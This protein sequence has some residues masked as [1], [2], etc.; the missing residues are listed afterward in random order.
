MVDFGLPP[1][2]HEWRSLR[3]EKYSELESVRAVA[4][5]VDLARGSKRR[6]RLGLLRRLVRLI[7]GGGD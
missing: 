5:Q 6:P 3:D 2:E 4:R 7:R 1:D